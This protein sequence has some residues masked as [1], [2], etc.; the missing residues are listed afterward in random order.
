MSNYFYIPPPYPFPDQW[1][2]I[3]SIQ[4]SEQWLTPSTHFCSINQTN[5]NRETEQKENYDT[6]EE[7]NLGESKVCGLIYDISHIVDNFG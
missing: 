3:A 6:V 4:T 5:V 2:R 1:N 7:R